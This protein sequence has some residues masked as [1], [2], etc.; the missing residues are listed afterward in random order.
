MPSKNRRVSR[1]MGEYFGFT[2]LFLLAVLGLTALLLY[3]SRP[4]PSSAAWET[5]PLTIILDAGHGGEDGGAIGHLNDREIYEKDLN[6][7]ITLMLRDMLEAEGVNVIL[8]RQQ[9]VLLYDRNTDYQGRKKILDLAARLHIG[10]STPNALFVS[11]H[12]NA[13][14]QPKYKGLQV[15]YSPNHALSAILAESMQTF[16]AQQLQKDNHRQIKRADSSIFLLEHLHC[17]AVLVECGFLSNP[18][19][20]R[21]LSQQEYQQKIAFVL[22]CAI[23]QTL[24]D[25]SPS[26]DDMVSWTKTEVLL[27]EDLIFD[28]KCFIIV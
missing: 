5:T 18:E 11:I 9:D 12:M 13:F 3:L 20:C 19:D 15:Y 2:L 16:T 28:P 23:R 7:A 22:F 6:L 26:K 27:P 25:Q 17:P 24:Q 1:I 10:E 8:T 21:L 4:T 14:T